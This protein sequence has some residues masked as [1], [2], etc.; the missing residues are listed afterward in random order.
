MEYDEIDSGSYSLKFD[1]Q[2]NKGV[3]EKF[4]HYC[5]SKTEKDSVF[6]ADVIDLFRNIRTN[7]EEGL[8]EL[9]ISTNF[10][11]KNT[12]SKIFIKKNI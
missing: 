11:L 5:L 6:E 3:Y 12:L 7:D 1:N 9:I 8:V 10:D 2:F 4:K